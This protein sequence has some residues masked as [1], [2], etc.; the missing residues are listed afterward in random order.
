V[1][2]PAPPSVGS[3]TGWRL[4]KKARAATWD[5][6][7]G[8]R[9]LGGRWNSAG[10]RAVYCSLDPSTTILEL[11]VHTGFDLLDT[12]PHVLTKFEL[13][14]PID[15]AKLKV[16][17]P[18]DIPNP[19]WLQSGMPSGGQQRFGDALLAAH[20]FVFVPSVIANH[21]WN[22]VFDP[23]AAAGLYALIAQEDFSLD[24]RLNPPSP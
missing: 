8:A 20:P 10:R 9:R 15:P 23:A 6:G 18:S 17:M 5:S 3:V 12:V 16:V 1:I 2:A 7:E 13:V 4:D 11:A 24:T 21:S 22:I 14:R 19:R